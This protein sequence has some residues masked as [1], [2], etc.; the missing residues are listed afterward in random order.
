M[1]VSITTPG[2]QIPS[3]HSQLVTI[4]SKPP[5]E[6]LTHDVNAAHDSQHEELT[7]HLRAIEDELLDLPDTLRKREAEVH[8]HIPERRP[9]D[10][11]QIVPRVL[12]DVPPW[13]RRKI[14][15]QARA[16][17]F[18]PAPSPTGPREIEMSHPFPM[19]LPTS[20]LGQS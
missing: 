2:S 7:D 10:C 12:E 13:S 17:P 9:E 14:G 18:S 19:P 4:I 3:I 6:I 15:M 1:S 8:V 16:A 11:P 20:S 5:C